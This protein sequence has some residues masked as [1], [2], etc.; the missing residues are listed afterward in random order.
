[1]DANE[2]LQHH[3]CR[4]QR[5]QRVELDAEIGGEAG[6]DVAL[7]VGFVGGGVVHEAHLAGRGEVG[8]LRSSVEPI[9]EIVLIT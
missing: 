6:V 9:A 3:I 5:H 8:A 2:P 4:L 1:M 7:E